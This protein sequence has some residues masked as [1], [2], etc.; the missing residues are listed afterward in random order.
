MEKKDP[1]N[2]PLK[3]GKTLLLFDIDG[4]LTEARK[5]IKDNMMECLKKASSFENIDLATIGGSDLPKAQEQLQSSIDLFKFVFTENGLV[6]LDEKK[7]LHK[8]NRIVNYLGYDK[9]K[10]FINFCLKYIA[11]LDI[12]VKTGTFIE[13]RTGLLNV[14]PIG[15]NCSQEERD[16]F[17]K[18]NKEHHILETFREILAQKFG[19][20]YGLEISIGGQISFDVYPNGWDKRFCLQFIEKLYDNIIFFGDKGYYGGNDYQIITNDKITK[21]IKVKNPETF[22][23]S[24][25]SVLLV[26]VVVVVF[27]VEE[28][29]SAHFPAVKVHLTLPSKV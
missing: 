10:E 24:P 22:K 20:K 28:V 16:A 1:T 9:L 13:L 18:Y 6:Y 29:F 17:D 26:V 25:L 21:G 23:I 7:E 27:P 3:K 11:D 4:T 2:K 15:R 12:P 5:I 14:S 8:V 19:E